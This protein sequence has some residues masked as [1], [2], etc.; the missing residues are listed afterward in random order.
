MNK[1]L[2][3]RALQCPD[4]EPIIMRTST[5]ELKVKEFAEFLDKYYAY[6]SSE[7]GCNLPMPDDL[8]WD[9][10]IKDAPQPNNGD[11]M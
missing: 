8:Y 1:L 11:G 9:A 2:P 5:K 7:L 10:L 6:A 4:G 3:K